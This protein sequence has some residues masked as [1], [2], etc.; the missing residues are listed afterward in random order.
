MD[1]SKTEFLPGNSVFCVCLVVSIDVLAG[2]A[3][4]G[5][6]PHR[7][8]AVGGKVGCLRVAPSSPVPLWNRSRRCDRLGCAIGSAFNPGERRGKETKKRRKSMIRLIK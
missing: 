5:N 6:S 8:L 3:S 2:L 7:P 1:G 4:R